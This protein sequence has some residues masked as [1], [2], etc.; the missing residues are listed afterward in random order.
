MRNILL[1]LSSGCALVVIPFLIRVRDDADMLVVMSKYKELTTSSASSEDPAL[2]A[3]ITGTAND[4]TAVPHFLFPQPGS[5]DVSVI[6]MLLPVFV[7]FILSL[8]GL[9]ID[10]RRTTKL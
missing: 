7:A 5:V 8:W 6:L 9:I 4:W 2:V 3:K 10:P 1:C